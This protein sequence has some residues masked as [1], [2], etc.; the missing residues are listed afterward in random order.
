MSYSFKK[1][2]SQ[3]TVIGALFLMLSA[4]GVKGKPLPPLSAP[5]IGRGRPTLA[6]PQEE[7]DKTDPKKLIEKQKVT[8]KAP[9]ARGE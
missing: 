4:C 1:T 6:Q 2:V 5:P 3:P 8:P 9:G 7:I